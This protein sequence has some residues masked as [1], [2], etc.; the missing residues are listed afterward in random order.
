MFFSNL[1]FS[2]PAS[3]KELSLRISGSSVD[4]SCTLSLKI[5]FSDKI[6]IYIIDSNLELC[7]RERN[8]L[9]CYVFGK[10]FLRQFC[11]LV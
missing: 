5:K 4:I 7:T 1:Y 3:G 6:I 11:R 10:N 9:R 2:K 8:N